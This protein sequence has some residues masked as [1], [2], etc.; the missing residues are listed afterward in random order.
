MGTGTHLH[1]ITA[2]LKRWLLRMYLNIFISLPTCS[3]TLTDSRTRRKIYTLSADLDNFLTLEELDFNARLCFV[4][5]GGLTPNSYLTSD[6][7]SS[8]N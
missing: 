8:A 1:P 5:A 7:F 2:I 6:L 3:S 4:H